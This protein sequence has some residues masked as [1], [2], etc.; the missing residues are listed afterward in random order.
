MVLRPAKDYMEKARST[1]FHEHF[2]RIRRRLR[3]EGD[4]ARSF[5]HGGNRGQVREAFVREFL[6]ENTS[7][8]CGIGTGEIINKTTLSGEKRSQ[9][10]VVIHN[11]RYPKISL[12][13]GIDLFFGETISSFI[14]IKSKL[15]KN[16]LKK[17]ASVS[18][19]LKSG[20]SL[21]PQR[22]NPS[23]LVNSPRPYSFL[24][25]YDGPE[26]IGT[27]LNWMKEISSKDDYNLD[28]L[29]RTDPQERGWF[30]N[31]FLDGVFILGKGCILVDALPS[32]SPLTVPI[33]EGV[34]VTL[35]HIWLQ[36]EDEL[37]LL[38]AIINGLSEQM[39]WCS[40]DM[41]EYVGMVE[42]RVSE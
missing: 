39:M 20:I 17:A 12:A 40:F 26:R 38:W 31:L 6:N 16:E 11:R 41:G 29:R 19:H 1:L 32:R 13:T 42:W 37:A 8:L 25:A 22:F 30:N 35:D 34:N 27:V 2:D 33:A 5:H 7:E 10:D 36:G 28:E 24:F 21:P 14:E 18:K 9:I 15:T 3:A 4:A 23:G